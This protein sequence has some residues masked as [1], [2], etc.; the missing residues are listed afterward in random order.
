MC[1]FTYRLSAQ[2]SPFHCT[3]ASVSLRPPWV[4]LKRH[5]RGQSASS[6]SQYCSIIGWHSRRSTGYK[7]PAA[8]FAGMDTGAGKD[9]MTMIN[10]H[11]N[12]T[13]E[14]KLEM[15]GQD[16]QKLILRRQATSY[17][18]SKHPAPYVYPQLTRHAPLEGQK[19]LHHPMMLNCARR[20]PA[21]RQ[22]C[23][24]RSCSSSLHVT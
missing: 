9:S 6:V 18:Q 14:E 16:V 19:A 13:Q 21:R 2:A 20:C 24:P 4:L 17:R 1:H 11:S 10:H 8:G 5:A 23:L 3:P 22:C 7:N 15:Q 12:P